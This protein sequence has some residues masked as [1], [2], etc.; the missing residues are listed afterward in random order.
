MTDHAAAAQGIAVGVLAAITA[1]GLLG[2]RVAVA[3]T[4]VTYTADGMGHTIQPGTRI[5]ES[6]IQNAHIDQADFRRMYLPFLRLIV[7]GKDNRTST[8]KV[9]ALAWTYAIFYG[10]LSLIVAKWLGAGGG[11]R[12]LLKHGLSDQYLILLG[13]PYAASV[14]AKYK[15]LSSTDKTTGRIGSASAKQLFTDDSGDADLGDFQYVLF[16]AL[17]LA[18]YLGTFIPH[19][20]LGMP[21]LPSLLSGLTLTS[22]GS[23]SAKKLVS[24]A[25]P[26]L[27][28]LLPALAPR[29]SDVEVWGNNLVIPASEAPGGSSLPPRVML[30]GSV[31]SVTAS[32]QTLG[33]DHLTVRIPADADAGQQKLTVVRADGVAALGPG[34]TDSLPITIF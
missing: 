14:L 21:R 23:Y 4:T 22:A 24:Q 25:S 19:L 12:A 27:T 20:Q 18:I 8:S 26:A 7:V 33:A 34:G 6:A 29:N 9:V 32:E 11:Y 2:R 31:I 10:L 3:T 1:L 17:A 13:G 16:N 30:A 28:S 5:P 15:A